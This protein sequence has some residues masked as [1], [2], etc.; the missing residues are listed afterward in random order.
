M[1]DNWQ[2]FLQKEGDYAWLPLETPQVEILEGRYQLIAHTQAVGRSVRIQSRYCYEAGDFPQEDL[3]ETVRAVEVSGQ[4]EV[5]P[6]L[7]LG[8]G[9]WFITCDFIDAPEGVSE[10][11]SAN[12]RDRAETRHHCLEI[13]VLP[14]EFEA[15]AQWD[16]TFP[17][18][19]EEVDPGDS[20]Q[21]DQ[22]REPQISTLE[23]LL[24]PSLRDW[25]AQV[26]APLDSSSTPLPSEPQSNL[27]SHSTPV[28]PEVTPL[29]LPV[30]PKTNPQVYFRTVEARQMPQWVCDQMP[31]KNHP[32]QSPQL[33]TFATGRS[34]IALRDL[35]R[36]RTLNRMKVLA[37]VV[38]QQP[39][40]LEISPETLSARLHSTLHRLADSCA[41]S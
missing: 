8:T 6:L 30:L 36:V 5:L 34:A 16:L 12:A 20:I 14:Q 38:S 28:L 2:F 26:A 33:P 10:G 25:S 27:D 22:A 31:R 3:Q 7:Y 11:V 9:D 15:F 1:M 18:S 39:P 23:G 40:A 29:T 37:T 35:D 19:P 17:P 24:D 21:L 32:G 41:V 4:V 13:Q